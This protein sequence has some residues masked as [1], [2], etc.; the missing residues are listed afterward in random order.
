MTINGKRAV[1]VLGSGPAG[2]LAAYA[3]EQNG[4]EVW[5][6]SLGAA[7]STM[8]GCQYLHEPIPG[9][10][11]RASVIQHKFTG[12]VE[13]Y[14]AKVYG[15]DWDGVVSPEQY[16]GDQTVYNIR[17]MYNSL[18]ELYGHR[19]HAAT[20]GPGGLMDEEKDIRQM[21]DFTFST[22]PQ[23]VLCYKNH[24]FKSA[25]IYAMG[26]SDDR[27]V[28][29]PVEDNTVHCAGERDI[30]WYR[31]SNVFGHSTVEWPSVGRKRPPIAG[32]VSVTKPISTDCDCFGWI[33]RIG[34]YGQWKKG[35]LSHHAYHD[36]HYLMTA[37]QQ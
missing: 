2:L 23:R 11:P 10:H 12:S 7:K 36:A 27:K 24:K 20:V 9:L 1:L 37:A 6:Q 16:S 21:F 29:I 17:D 13:G 30:S 22:I 25:S 34:R 14:R 31:A 32:V 5:I 19:V 3:A 4:Y 26:D 15:M 8:Y 18:W 35:V 28:P 33:H